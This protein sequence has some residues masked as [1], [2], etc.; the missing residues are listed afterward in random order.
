MPTFNPGRP[1]SDEHSAHHVQYINLVPDGNIVELLSQQLTTLQ[2][3]LAPLSAEQAHFRPKPDDWN[4]L[5]VLGHI[6]DGER[7][8]V[9]RALTFARGDNTPLPNFD[10]DVFMAGVNFSQRTLADMLDEL[11]TV[12]AAT[13]SFFRSLAPAA[14]DRRGIASG[15]L[16]SVRALAYIAAGHELHHVA[17]FRR[18]Y[19]M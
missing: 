1:S 14:W 16:V 11:A 15:N 17:D 19:G 4:I 2:A 6:A 13:L 8:F 7:V 12:R 9:Y 10:Q 5:Q 3:L 18:R